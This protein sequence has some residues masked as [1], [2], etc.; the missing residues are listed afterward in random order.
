MPYLYRS[1]AF[2]FCIRY[3]TYFI[4]F[5]YAHEFQTDSK[6]KHKVDVHIGIYAPFSSHSAFIGRNILAAME[7][8]SERLQSSDIH[9]SFYTLDQSPK[10]KN[11]GLVLQ[12]LLIPIISMCW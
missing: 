5:S 11:A 2:V 10:N 9:Y 7:M 12:N 4:N 6:N 1:S 8:G 3:R